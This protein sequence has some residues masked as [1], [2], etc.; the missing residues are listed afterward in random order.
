MI[1]TLKVLSSN[2]NGNTN[3]SNTLTVKTHLFSTVVRHNT[4]RHYTTAARIVSAVRPS[5]HITPEDLHLLPVSQWVV[6]KTALI[7]WKCVHGV[8][9]V[10]L[11]D[12]CISATAMSG[13][14][15]LQQLVI[16]QFHAP[17]LQLD[18]EVSQST[19]QR[20][21]TVCHQHDIIGPVEEHVQASTE[22]TLFS[23]AQRHR[24]VFMILV[25]DINLQTYLLT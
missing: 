2:T 9:P 5:E 1:N 4:P 8:V 25:P 24:D 22:D 14:Q 23:T 12:L 6:F 11:S 18:N 20:H 13:C 19:D 10:Y 3:N 15:H 21:G 16:Y 7:V 17:G